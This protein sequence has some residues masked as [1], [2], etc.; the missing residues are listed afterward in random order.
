MASFDSIADRDA[1]EAQGSWEALGLPK[2]LY[3][4]LTRTRDRV[5]D[6]PAISFQIL[7]KPGSRACTLTWDEFHQRCLLYTSDAAD[8]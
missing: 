2:T 8:E 4:Y 5:P 6:R 3:G 7:S 1:I